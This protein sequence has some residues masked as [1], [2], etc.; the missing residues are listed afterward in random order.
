MRSPGRYRPP[1][2]PE[3]AVRGDNFCHIIKANP[4]LWGNFSYLALKQSGNEKKKKRDP[5]VSKMSPKSIFG[6]QESKERKKE[7]EEEREE[8]KRGV[9]VGGDHRR[10]P[11]AVNPHPPPVPLAH[12]T[13]ISLWGMAGPCQQLSC[14][15]PLIHFNTQWRAHQT[16]RATQD[17]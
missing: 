11:L 1:S 15:A 8:I 4:L 7:K 9:G 6:Q 14:L 10:L 17:P 12:P 13:V 3:T 5:S 16:L 2:P